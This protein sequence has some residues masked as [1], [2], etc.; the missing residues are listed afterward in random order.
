MPVPSDPNATIAPT[1]EVSFTGRG[2]YPVAPNGL[3]D[4]RYARV[5]VIVDMNRIPE[6]LNAVST[7]NFMSVIDLDFEAIDPQE[8][9]REG[10]VFGG[11]AVVRASLRVETVWLRSWMAEWMPSGVRERLGIPD[12]AGDGAADDEFG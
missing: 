10:F 12:P 7:T 9:L 6:L 5:S 1:F 3:Y 11:D 8:A 2:G 4:V